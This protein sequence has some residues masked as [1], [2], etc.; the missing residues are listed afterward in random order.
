MKNLL[1]VLGS[2]VWLSLPGSAAPCAPGTLAAYIALGPA[3]CVL[4]NLHVSGFAYQAD[5]SG[6]AAQITADQISVTPLLA[7]GGNFALQFDAPWKVQTAQ[8]QF[9][10]IRYRVVSPTASIQVQQVRLDG[11]GFTGGMFGS[12]V[13]DETLAS[14]ATASDLQ[15]FIKCAEVCKSQTSATLNISPAVTALIVGDRVNLK[16][17]LGSFSFTGFVDWLV[18]CAACV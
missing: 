14:A 1:V 16:S 11:N 18:V 13:I 15:V 5:S 8:S 6:G 9:S 12:I 3:G 17:K 2:I 7:P 10:G 4:G